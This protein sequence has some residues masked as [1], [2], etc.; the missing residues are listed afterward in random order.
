MSNS[1]ELYSFAACPFAQ[2]TRMVLAE[3]SI[4]HER[5][6]IDLYNRPENWK[7]IS[8]TGKVPLL[9]HRGATIYESTIINQYLDESFPE[10]PLMP[11]TALGRAQARI[12]MDHC[13][14]RFL[15]TMHNLMRLR[16]DAEKLPD[17]SDKATAVLKEL[18]TRGMENRGDG[19][20]W[21]GSQPT[22]VDFQYLPFFERMPVYEALCDFVWPA[23]CMQ[24]K[25]WFAAMCELDSVSATLRP[26]DAHIEQQQ[27]LNERIAAAR[28][29]AA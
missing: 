9:R 3:K 14:H 5:H 15:G 28:R 21:L 13:D 11:D 1:V 17:A 26:V 7:E 8:P 2:R 12:W 24:L 25:D 4:D 20:Y 22:L 6:E 23:E 19:P 10:R 27:R 29:G 18:E 16:D